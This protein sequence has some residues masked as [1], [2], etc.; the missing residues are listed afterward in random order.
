[1]KNVKFLALLLGFVFISATAQADKRD[2]SLTNATGYDIKSVF[3]DSSHS[4]SWS[5][6]IMGR[7]IFHDGETIDVHF[8]GADKGCKWDMKIEWTDGEP[9]TEWHDFDLCQIT[10]I[11]LKY[12]RKTGA[13]TAVTN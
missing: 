8:D 9:A 4:N 3:V 13:T 6:D 12:N 7:D 2:F 5:D 11:T 10:S 1:M